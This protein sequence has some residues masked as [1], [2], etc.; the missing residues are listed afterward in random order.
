M[1]ATWFR[2]RMSNYHITKAEYLSDF[3]LPTDTVYQVTTGSYEVT[4]VE[5]RKSRYFITAQNL[6]MVY[7]YMITCK[8]K[9]EK[10]SHVPKVY[11]YKA[12][13]VPNR[14]F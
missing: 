1:N 11:I 10:Q 7:I 12:D 5:Y 2:Y 13:I 4:Y 9:I 8:E 6:I 3:Q 14:A